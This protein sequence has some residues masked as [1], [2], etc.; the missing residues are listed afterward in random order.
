[1]AIS[2]NY[3]KNGYNYYRKTKKFGNIR[4]EFYGKGKKDVEKQIEEY[5]EKIKSG[6]NVI[7]LAH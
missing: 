6:L 1:M 7:K 3:T 5:T 2:Y 4:K